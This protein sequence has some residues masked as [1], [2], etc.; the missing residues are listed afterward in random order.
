MIYWMECRDNILF[1]KKYKRLR[2]G[3]TEVIKM[4]RKPPARQY[5]VINISPRLTKEEETKYIETI[6]PTLIKVMGYKEVTED[7]EPK[8]VTE[9]PPD[10]LGNSNAAKKAK[11]FLKEH[12]E[13]MAWQ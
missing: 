11:E 6:M 5:T 10:K 12:P 9:V 4:P 2:I 7:Y 8:P 3:F 13:Y 1:G